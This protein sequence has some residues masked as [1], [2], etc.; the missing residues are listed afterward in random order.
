MKTYKEFDSVFFFVHKVHGRKHE[1]EQK[2]N[3]T[4]IQLEKTRTTKNS[5]FKN[6]M[7]IN[8]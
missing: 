6:G 1:H 5:K 7:K 8:K 3:I 2:H 4:N